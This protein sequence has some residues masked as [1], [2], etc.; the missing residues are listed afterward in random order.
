MQKE[1]ENTNS[2]H[3]ENT[4]L[5]SKLAKLPLTNN[6]RGETANAIKII[7]QTTLP[8]ELMMK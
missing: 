4:E 5:P 6:S 7:I 1:V 2:S 8:F 3:R